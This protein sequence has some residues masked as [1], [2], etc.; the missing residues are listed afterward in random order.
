MK[1]Y[2]FCFIVSVFCLNF[3]LNQDNSRDCPDNFSVSPQS[4]LEETI[5]VPNE[6]VHY[7]SNIQA[8]YLFE[9]IIIEGLQ[10]EILDCENPNDC[11]WVGAFN[12]NNDVCVGA[13]M[14]DLNSCLSNPED[15][16]CVA[17]ALN[18]QNNS[19]C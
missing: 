8:G 17:D 13:T 5:C 10:L 12:P 14:W 11:D 18:V 3:L 1:F 19:D 15:E 6:F 9:S 2:R 16:I 7:T 4:T